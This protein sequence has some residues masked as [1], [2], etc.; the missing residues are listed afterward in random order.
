[1][2]KRLMFVAG[3]AVGY[4]FGTRAGR[5]QYDK[6]CKLAQRVAGN[7]AVQN[8]AHSAADN[9]RAA[10]VK[11]ADTVVD[12]AGNRLPGAVT[13]KVRALRDKAAPHD[14]WGTGTGNG[15]GTST[16]TGTP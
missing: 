5:E 1:M 15:A 8:A 6:L 7:P 4:V 11:A 13:D 14:D 16:G 10:A 9:S 12:R 3:A 2:A